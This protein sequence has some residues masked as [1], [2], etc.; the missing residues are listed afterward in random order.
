MT[1][2]KMNERIE[3]LEN[4]KAEYDSRMDKK[5]S[6]LKKERDLALTAQ[7]QKIFA[8]HHLSAEE[9]IKLKYANKEQ[10]KQ[11]LKVIDEIEEPVKEKQED[12]ADS[13]NEKENENHAKEVTN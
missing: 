4:E 10:L 13:K 11:L 8:R 12:P 6:D 5:I 3:R 2:E 9:L 1:I 7:T